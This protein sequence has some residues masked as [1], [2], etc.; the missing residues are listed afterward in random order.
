MFFAVKR[1]CPAQGW[2]WLPGMVSAVVA[3]F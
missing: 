1:D 2:R 3:D